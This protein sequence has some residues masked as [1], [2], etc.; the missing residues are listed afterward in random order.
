MPKAGLSGK[1]KRQVRSVADISKEIQGLMT[2]V[3]GEDVRD[4]MVSVAEKENA[5]AVN[6]T[7]KVNQ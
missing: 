3:Y 2:A 1:H 4:S 6:Y 7:Q 5:G